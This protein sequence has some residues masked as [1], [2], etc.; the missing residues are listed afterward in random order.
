METLTEREWCPTSDMRLPSCLVGELTR[1]G[2]C[3]CCKRQVPVYREDG[4][5][6]FNWHTMR[7]ESRPTVEVLPPLR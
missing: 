3:H 5:W 4:H 7:P 1:L 6:V 2:S